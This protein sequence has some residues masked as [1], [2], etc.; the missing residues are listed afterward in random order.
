MTVFFI[1]KGWNKIN[2]ALYEEFTD[3]YF[4]EQGIYNVQLLKMSDR[5]VYGYYKQVYQLNFG[6]NCL[7]LGD[8]LS[9]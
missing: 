3:N 8:K 6:K 4:G 5:N 1:F 2:K 9:G 7:I